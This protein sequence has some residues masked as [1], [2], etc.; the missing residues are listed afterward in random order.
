[1]VQSELDKIPG[2]GPKRRNTLL[3]QFK[4]ITEIKQASVE[5]ITKLGI[6]KNVAEDVLAH[7]NED[8]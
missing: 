2:V 8:A 6:P 5:D 1:M 4:S 3:K 7:L